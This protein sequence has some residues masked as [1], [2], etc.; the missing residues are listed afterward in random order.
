M[1][2]VLLGIVMCLS[3][4]VHAQ[5]DGTVLLHQAAHCLAAKNFLPPSKAV[6]RSFGYLLDE[7]SYP[8]E[9][10]LYIVE[11]SKPSRS[12]GFVFTIFLTDKDGSHGFNIQ[13]NARFTLSKSRDGGVSF[14]T[15]PLGG[16]WTQEHLVLAIKRIEK[17]P[18]VTL[19][20]KNLL[21]VESSVSCEAYTDPQPQPATK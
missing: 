19:S 5:D 17:Q 8:G 7:K 2:P 12:D 15:P 10:M 18:K 20:M 21:T 16:T 4:V 1:K 3:C 6:E 11:Y 13:N 9:K 14:A